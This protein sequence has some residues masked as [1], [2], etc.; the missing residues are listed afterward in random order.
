V[1][2]TTAIKAGDWVLLRRLR[3]TNPRAFTGLQHL[4]QAANDS[5]IWIGVA[6]IVASTGTQ[7]RRSAAE[8]LAAV[9]GTSMLVNGPLKR[10]AHRAR[11][12]GILAV[13]VAPTGR[14]PST[15]SFPSGHAAA[16][17][18]F[19]TAAGWRSP[20]LAVPLSVLAAAIGWSRVATVRHFPTDIAAGAAVGGI[21]GALTHIGGTR[22]AATTQP[23]CATPTDFLQYADT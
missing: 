4:S 20:R 18:A 14:T 8:G 21:C 12:A 6:V 5:K 11:P 13:G 3:P 9:A 23:D 7:G 15:S 16:A 2:V 19:A 22:L 10:V 1:K 17:A